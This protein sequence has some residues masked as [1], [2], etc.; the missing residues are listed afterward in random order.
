MN[1]SNVSRLRESGMKLSFRDLGWQ[2]SKMFAESFGEVGRIFEAHLEGDFRN[3][4][5]ALPQQVGRAFQAIGAQEFIGRLIR[6][7]GDLAIKLHAT[8]AHLPRQVLYPKP[9]IL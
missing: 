3:I 6:E 9:G 5:H 2:F 1:D 4:S 8:Q 7:R